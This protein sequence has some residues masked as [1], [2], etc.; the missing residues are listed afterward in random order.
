MPSNVGYKTKLPL[1]S[2]TA[3]GCGALSSAASS[4]SCIRGGRVHDARVDSTWRLQAVVYA[5]CPPERPSC[6]H[7]LRPFCLPAATASLRAMLAIATTLS[8]IKVYCCRCAPLNMACRQKVGCGSAPRRRGGPSRWG[9]AG[10]D[11]CRT[12]ASGSLPQ[13]IRR[14]SASAFQSRTGRRALS[15]RR[16]HL[17][18]LDRGASHH[19]GHQRR[20]R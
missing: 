16:V 8:S 13:W 10:T 17:Q 6:T 2:N 20:A 18:V 9:P 14:T 7:S 12:A 19:V 11:R 4:L 5:W 3:L 1:S 15:C